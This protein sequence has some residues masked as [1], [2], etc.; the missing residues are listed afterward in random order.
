MNTEIEIDEQLIAKSLLYIT[1]NDF[2]Y[3]K[4]KTGDWRRYRQAKDWLFNND[5]D[6]EL[7]LNDVCEILLI[8]KSQLRLLLNSYKDKKKIRLV[9]TEF[10]KLLIICRKVF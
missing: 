3:G 4:L 1:I 5:N 2:L 7:S 10:N 9:E 6:S 8:D